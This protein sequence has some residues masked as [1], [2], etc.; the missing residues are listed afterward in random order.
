LHFR[1]LVHIAHLATRPML[2]I[3]WEECPN[4]FSQQYFKPSPSQLQLIMHQLGVQL[5]H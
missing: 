1:F 5:D 4:A 3:L 2:L